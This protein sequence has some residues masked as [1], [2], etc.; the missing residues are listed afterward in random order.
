MYGFGERV[1]GMEAAALES[2]GIA[3]AFIGLWWAGVDL[4]M[5]PNP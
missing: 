4:Y 3:Q 5:I 2:T 1:D